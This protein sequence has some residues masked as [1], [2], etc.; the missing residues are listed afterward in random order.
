MFRLALR[1]SSAMT[2]GSQGPAGQYLHQ[3]LVKVTVVVR[4]GGAHMPGHRGSRR[5]GILRDNGP[6]D[7]P[8]LRGEIAR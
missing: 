7:L 3:R 8:E 6:Q 1:N 4:L 5:V 2:A